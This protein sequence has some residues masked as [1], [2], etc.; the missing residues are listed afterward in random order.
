[1]TSSRGSVSSPGVAVA[2][3][4]A[5]AVAA[6]VGSALALG[7]PAAP[8]PAPLGV[9]A[10]EEYAALDGVTATRTTVVERGDATRKTV[11]RVALD[12]GTER[13]R[14]RV[15]ESDAGRYD[16]R[17]SDG[18]VLSLYDRDAGEVLRIPLSGTAGE[19]SVGARVERL[20]ARLN[21]TASTTETSVTATGVSPLPVVPATGDA[22]EPASADVGRFRLAFDGTATVSG[23]TTYVLRVSRPD[24]GG[25]TQTLWVDASHWFPV[26]QRTTWAEDGER[27]TVTT[28]YADLSFDPGLGADA[29]SFDPPANAT[30]ETA[31]TPE[32]T[33]YASVDALRAASNVSVPE[34][35]LPASF[36]ATYASE[37]TGRI[38]GVGLRYVNETARVT[39][40]KYDR[41]FPARGD[42]EVTVAGHDAAV[43][44]GPTTSVSWNCEHYRYTVRGQGVPVDVL[45]AVAESVA[46]E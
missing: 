29:F 11:A 18:S 36:R 20:F 45:L 2:A 6:A 9:D 33:T 30:V 13:R 34:P 8:T 43:S 44:V 15:L 31:D 12:P 19:P 40:G 41:T 25:F 27:V 14:V 46:C 42:R 38:H 22:P 5:V 32:T 28:T 35:V 3:A 39:V 24:G 23:R 26:K 7:T 4:V 21:V 37:T 1:M 17:V 10:S 16:R